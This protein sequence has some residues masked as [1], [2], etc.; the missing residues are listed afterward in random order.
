VGSFA[1]VD[2]AFPLHMYPKVGFCLVDSVLALCAKAC[3]VAAQA[4]FYIHQSETSL[5]KTKTAAAS[6]R[7]M[8]ANCR[9]KHKPTLREGVYIFSEKRFH[10]Q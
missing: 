7:V 5:I 8:L 6:C 10:Y 9:C 2:C 1:C 3:V 4:K